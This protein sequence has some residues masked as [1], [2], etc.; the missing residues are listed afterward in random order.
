M[1]YKEYEKL[2]FN[3]L[4]K[5]KKYPKKVWPI[6]NEYFSRYKSELGLSEEEINLKVDKVLSNLDIIRNDGSAHDFWNGL[7]IPDQKEIKI[8]MENIKRYNLPDEQVINT[9]FHELNHAGEN[10]GKDDTTSFQQY[11][12]NTNRFEGV[13]FNEIITEMKSSRLACNDRAELLSKTGNDREALDLT[14][15]GDLIFMGTML[16][17]ALGIG[18]REFLGLADKGKAEFDRQMREKFPPGD[19]TYDTFINSITYY[20][21]M[22]HAIKYNENREWSE[23][24]K[25]NMIQSMEGIKDHCIYAMGRRMS[26]EA[27]KNRD[28]LNMEQFTTKC[29]YE[30]DKIDINYKKGMSYI[31]PNEEIDIE[32]TYKDDVKRK[33]MEFE[34]LDKNKDKLS[35]AQ[36]SELLYLSSEGEF[37]SDKLQSEYGITSSTDI[38]DFDK[39]MELAYETKLLQDEYGDKPWNNKELLSDVIKFS[40]SNFLIKVSKEYKKIAGNIKSMINDYKYRKSLSRLPEA[41]EEMDGKPVE[42]VQEDIDNNLLLN[43]LSGMVKT[44]D[45][46]YNHLKSNEKKERTLDDRDVFR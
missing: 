46:I 22:L 40:K 20:S 3:S 28:S 27:F 34:T 7:F 31:L 23:Q 43:D 8:N 11:N 19:E 41:K 10:L 45:E 42:L 6:L 5:T 32:S 39:T 30:L 33:I 9:I 15:Y 38:N 37:I 25:Q 35:F 14:G 17:T 2:N 36:Q 4:F 29:R 1:E 21:D 16:H 13:A 24:D 18:E 44:E 12:S 26:Y